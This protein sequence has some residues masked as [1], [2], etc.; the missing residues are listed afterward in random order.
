MG[1]FFVGHG[2]R[3]QEMEMNGRLLTG[4]AALALLAGS[5]MPASATLVTLN[6]GFNIS[7]D[8]PVAGHAD[9]TG[10]L[11]LT[12]TGLT[13]TEVDLSV[14]LANTTSL[15]EPSARLTGFGWDSS[16]SATGGSET[17]SVFGLFVNSNF[18]AFS[19]IDVCL[20][21]G[22][23]CAGGAN[24]GLSPGQSDSFTMK[25]FYTNTTGLDFST[26]ATKFQTDFG[27]FEVAGTPTPTPV[28]EPAMTGIFGLSLLGLAML[29]RRRT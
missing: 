8:Q 25:L 16:P 22:N 23:T 3:H 29:K 27:S 24:G 28:P 12:V 14:N 4:L 10:T 5:A 9:L 11:G 19:Q 13:A 7:F 17:S 21:S 15:S 20:S 26:F 18:P 6:E 2:T 1:R